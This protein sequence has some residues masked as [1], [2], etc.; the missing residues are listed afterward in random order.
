[1]ASISGTKK[2][3]SS[4]K[5]VSSESSFTISKVVSVSSLP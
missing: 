5:I 1:M 2:S 4:S 3:K